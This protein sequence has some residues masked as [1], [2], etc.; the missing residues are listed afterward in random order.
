MAKA[1]PIWPLIAQN[2]K[3]KVLTSIGIDEVVIVVASLRVAI[4]LV[5]VRGGRHGDGWLRSM[6]HNDCWIPV[7]CTL[8]MGGFLQ[9]A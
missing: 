8:S 7:I 3:S 5:G 9:T 4:V 6:M 1:D 2:P